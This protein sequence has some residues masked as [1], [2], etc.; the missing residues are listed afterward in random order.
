MS[1]QQGRNALETLGVAWHQHQQG[2]GPFAV[3]QAEGFQHLIVLAF[4]SAGSDENLA[5]LTPLLAQLFCLPQQAIIH[6]QVELDGTGH[7]QRRR[8]QAQLDETLAVGFGLGGDDGD[9]PQHGAGEGQHAAVTLGRLFRQP[10]IGDQ[11]RNAALV[12][13]VNQIRPQLGFQHH[14]D[15]RTEAAEETVD[16]RG[17]LI[18]QIDVDHPAGQ[19]F[20]GEGRLHPLRAGGGHGGDDNGGVGIGLQEPPDQGLGRH[21]LA[22]GDS[23]EPETGVERSNTVQAKPLGNALTITRIDAAALIE[24]EQQERGGQVEGQGV[25]P[26]GEHVGILYGVVFEL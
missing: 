24:P 2:I 20:S 10:R 26:A 4:V 3:N 18:G 7:L 12:G 23:V 11:D 14:Q 1:L 22:N 25:E 21:K 5:L 19:D 16:G 6:I 8:R 13:E 15:A 17:Q 9:L